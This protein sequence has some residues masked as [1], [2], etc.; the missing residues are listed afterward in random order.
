MIIWMKFYINFQRT[1]LHL[2]IEKRNETIIKALLG[3][4]GIDTRV[5]DEVILISLNK[6]FINNFMIFW[7][8]FNEEHQWILVI[9][10]ISNHYY[11]KHVFSE[12]EII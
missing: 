11:W 12:R 10:G 2:A 1:A 8:L 4:P 6:V 9:V 3:T 7:M 5:K